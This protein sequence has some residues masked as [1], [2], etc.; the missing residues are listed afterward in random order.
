MMFETHDNSASQY[1]VEY[2]EKLKK[3]FEDDDSD[4]EYDLPFKNPEDLH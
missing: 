1:E 4:Q 2:P 3:L